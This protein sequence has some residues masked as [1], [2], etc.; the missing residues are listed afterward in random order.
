[1]NKTAVITIVVLAVIV[2]GFF[3]INS[4]NT[5]ENTLNEEPQGTSSLNSLETDNELFTEMDTA[6]NS[7]E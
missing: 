7:L 5:S 4:I 6:I 3:A 2:L 1:M